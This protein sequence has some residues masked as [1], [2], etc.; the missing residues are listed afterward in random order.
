MSHYGLNLHFLMA[1]DVEHHSVCSF[2]ICTS[3]V[4][5]LLT[6]FAHFLFGLFLFVYLF[7]LLS[8]EGLLCSL[9]AHPLLKYS[10]QTIPPHPEVIF[11]FSSKGLLQNQSLS[12]RFLADR[13]LSINK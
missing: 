4:K 6:Y 5:C 2:A 9:D 11:S 10:L 12:L 7:F 3:P 1:N 8:V 13:V